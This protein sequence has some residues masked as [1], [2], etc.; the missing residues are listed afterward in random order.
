MKQDAVEFTTVSKDIPRDYLFDNLRAILIILVVWG[1][2]LTSMMGKSEIIKSI[3]FFLFFFHMPAMAFVSGYFSKNLDKIRSNAFVTILIPYLILNVMNYTYKM[4][5]IQEHYYG[6]RFFRP[7]WGLWYLLALFLWK[8][9]LKD[10]VKIRFLLPLSFVFAVLSGFTKEF[11]DY[12]AL[13]RTLCFLPFFLLGFYC[14]KEQVAKIRRIPKVV[15]FAAIVA[16]ALISTYIVHNKVFKVEVLYLRR[17]YPESSDIK[18]MVFRI[19]VYIVASAMIIAIINITTAKKTFL[20]IIGTSTMT[21][22]I[23]HLFTIPLL[24]KLEILKEQPYLY[25]SYSFF[26]TA[27]IVFIYTRPFVRRIYDNIMDKLTRLIVKTE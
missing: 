17:P 15:S 7:Y 21:V 16:T 24:E 2:V 13:G 14:T 19:L 3:Y 1:H 5:V 12:M 25:L 11:S 9:F 23:L 20:S 10:L 26:M 8:F 22:Y 6:F 18:S 4:V 27:V